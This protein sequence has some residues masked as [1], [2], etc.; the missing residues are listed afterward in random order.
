MHEFLIPVKT[1]AGLNA[2][3]L[4]EIFT[5]CEDTGDLIRRYKTGPNVKLG[6]VAGHIDAQG[7]RRVR[8][9]GVTCAAHRV[10]WVMVHGS[11]PVGSIDHINGVRS[12]NRAANLRD[13]SHSVNLQNQRKPRSDNVLGVQ[14]VRALGGKYEARIWTEGRGVSLGS[15]ATAAEASTAYRKAKRAMHEG[16][17]I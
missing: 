5:Y 7:Y 15:F 16:C 6:V 2:I 12:D 3:R 8:V 9:D 1:V 10:A 14:G 4:H 17:T 11:E 13:V